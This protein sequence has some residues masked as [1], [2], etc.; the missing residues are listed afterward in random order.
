MRHRNAI[1]GLGVATMGCISGMMNIEHGMQAVGRAA[2]N[3]MIHSGISASVIMKIHACVANHCPSRFS[4]FLPTAIP[5][6]LSA[7]ACYA[8]H[9]FG[10]PYI[11]PPSAEP[12]LS[13]IP[14]V[15]MLSVVIPTYHLAYYKHKMTHL[16]SGKNKE[17]SDEPVSI[18]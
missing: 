6:A 14:T 12:A 17:S 9:R 10:I 2:I 5:A 3:Q 7:G 13:T 1:A 16:L 18:Q 4:H 15:I 8:I 11:R